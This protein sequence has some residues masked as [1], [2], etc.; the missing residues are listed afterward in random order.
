MDIGTATFLFIIILTLRDSLKS[1]KRIF[2]IVLLT[3]TLTTTILSKTDFARMNNKSKIESMV[4]TDTGKPYKL[5]LPCRFP[6]FTNPFGN[7][8]PLN[9]R[10]RKNCSQQLEDDMDSKIPLDGFT[11]REGF[12]ISND[13]NDDNKTN[14][15]KQLAKDSRFFLNSLKRLSKGEQV[16]IPSDDEEQP[17]DFVQVVKKPKKLSKDTIAY[18]QKFTE[19]YE[20][21]YETKLAEQNILKAHN[22]KYKVNQRMAYRLPETNP[23]PDVDK[24]VNFIKNDFP[25]CKSVRSDCMR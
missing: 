11:S 13:N 25:N 22:G 1:Y 6:S 21:D 12:D 10:L 18:L 15:L 5:T 19:Q 16:D 7:N 17:R 20:S 14:S 23:I 24:F 4:S 8:L 3:L 9:S 2:D